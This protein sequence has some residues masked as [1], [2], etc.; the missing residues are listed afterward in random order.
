MNIMLKCNE[1]KVVYFKYIQSFR[2]KKYD[3]ED[4]LLYISW[5]GNIILI[6]FSNANIWCL[7]DVLNNV[8]VQ[9]N[10]YMQKNVVKFEIR[11]PRYSG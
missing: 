11:I 9:K 4:Q 10:N 7:P 1:W 5:F 3:C 8:K 2:I 6:F